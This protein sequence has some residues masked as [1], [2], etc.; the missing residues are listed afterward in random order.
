MPEVVGVRFR[1]AGRIYFFAPGDLTINKDDAVI[2]ETIRGVE[3]GQ[4]AYAP[5]EVCA[6]MV[7]PYLPLK[8]VIRVAE[9]RDLAQK[10]LLLKKAESAYQICQERILQHNLAMKLLDAEYTLDGAKLIFQFTAEGRIDFRELVRDLA[11]VFKTR[12]ELRQ[13]GVRDEAKMIGGLGGCGRELCCSAFLGDFLP[14]SIKMARD[15]NLSL[16]P[17]KISGVC[18]R[19]LCCLNYEMEDYGVQG[20][21]IPVIVVGSMVET[22]AGRG[23]VMYVNTKR[24]LARVRNA[25]SGKTAEFPLDE[26]IIILPENDESLPVPE[27]SAQ[28]LP[29]CTCPNAF[30]PS[31]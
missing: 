29:S 14:V 19:L 25:E 6:K 16:N 5:R 23:K 13:V 15:Q 22:N 30:P 20:E 7:A 10:E 8:Q 24:N 2:V 4:V 11:A 31:H 26:L 12:I 18:G 17:T 21:L 9:A 1:H 28:V 27:E 3:M